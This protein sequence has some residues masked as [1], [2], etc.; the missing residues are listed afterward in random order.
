MA[1]ND[2][3]RGVTSVLRDDRASRES[4]APIERPSQIDDPKCHPLVRQQA[5]QFYAGEI[6]KKASWTPEETKFIGEECAKYAKE[7]KAKK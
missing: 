4:K 6:L 1:L 7:E 3:L 2:D 5:A